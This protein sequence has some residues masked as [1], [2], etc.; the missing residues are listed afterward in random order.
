[1]ATIISNIIL[2]CLFVFVLCMIYFILASFIDVLNNIVDTMFRVACC[3]IILFLMSV[4]VIF[5][6]Y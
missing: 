5:T 3:D 1:M 6:L 2:I 4:I